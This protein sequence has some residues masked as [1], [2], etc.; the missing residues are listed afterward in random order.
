MF[1]TYLGGPGNETIT[2]VTVDTQGNIYVVGETFGNFPNPT[3][4]AFQNQL[5]GRTDAFIIKIS[6]AIAGA[7]SNPGVSSFNI[8]NRSGVSLTTDGSSG[9]VTA[10]YA[11]IQP[12]SGSTTPSGLAIFG[13]RGEAFS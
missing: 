12:G 5:R 10:G 4:G 6:P 2:G 3:S 9:S 11:R 7:P 8:S 1:S 13:F